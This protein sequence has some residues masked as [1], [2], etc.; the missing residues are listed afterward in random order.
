MFL[1]NI[2]KFV[3]DNEKKKYVKCYVIIFYSISVQ[4]LNF[5]ISYTFYVSVSFS[6]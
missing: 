5:E 4:S 6:D 1:Q 2:C 3:I